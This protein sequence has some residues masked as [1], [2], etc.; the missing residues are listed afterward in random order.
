M[1]TVAVDLTDVASEAK[2][3]EAR[4][5]AR[6]DHV[7]WAAGAFDWAR[8]D[9]ADADAWANLVHINLVAA[10][11]TTRLVLPDLVAAGGGSLVY[12]ASLAGLDVFANNAAYVASKHGLVAFARAVFLDVRDHG[13]KVCAVCPG[14]VD[15]G[16]TTGFPSEQRGL[17]LRPS[18]IADAVLYVV[19]SSA[20]AC[21]TEIRLEPQ[22]D[23]HRQ[24][25]P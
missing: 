25:G 24:S 17:F 16:A 15:A 21:P 6:V 10:M 18:D 13:V 12:I 8:A 2:M 1:A 4:E 9:V 11:R 22:L 5:T 19:T 23:P 20:T 7:V 14:L 3:D